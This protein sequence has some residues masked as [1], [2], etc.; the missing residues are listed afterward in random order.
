MRYPVMTIDLNKYKTNIETLTARLSEYH[1]SV[2]V[3]TKVFRAS[4]PLLKIINDSDVAYVADSRL[5]NLKTVK[6]TKP[7]VLVRIPMISEAKDVVRFSD[8]SLNS[9]IGTIKALDDAAK[10]IRT[11]HGI[12]LMF[13]LGDLREG[14]YYAADYM[15]DVKKI[16][17]MS[18]V[19]LEGIGCNLTCYGGVIPTPETL[20]KLIVIKDHIEQET[21][22]TLPVI[23]GGN[24]SGLDLIFSGKQPLGINNLRLGEAFVLGRETAYGKP[25]KGMHDDVFTMRAELIEVKDKPSYPEGLLGVNAFGEKVHFEDQGIMT[26]GILA[27]GRQDVG[28]DDLIPIDGITVLGC[29]SDHTIVTF[30]KGAYQVGDIL[31]FKLTYGGILRGMHASDVE[32]VYV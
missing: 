31:E 29:S 6:T 19:R 3:V 27:L 1:T 25:I 26:R 5:S 4:P 11:I 30:E 7:K 23:S 32:K 2:M 12:I 14:I 22:T 17:A 15:D 13:D 18:H 24:S 10:D 8:I 21:G 28:C 9:E 16:M 20:M